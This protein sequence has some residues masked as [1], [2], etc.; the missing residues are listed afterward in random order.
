MLMPVNRIFL[1]LLCFVLTA[2]AKPDYHTADGGSG[3]FAEIRGKWLV[4]NYWADWCKP[5]IQEIPELNRFNQQHADRVVMFAVNY[6]GLLGNELNEQIE[7]LHIKV[8]VLIEDPSA[9]LSYKRPDALPTT[10][11]FGPDGQLK[12]TLEGPQTI[13]SLSAAIE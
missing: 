10:L 9:V 13:T 5:C 7:K 2:C 4:I 6:D 3:R 8:P 12:K 11:I 1:P